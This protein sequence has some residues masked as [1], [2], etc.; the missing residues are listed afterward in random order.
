ME[1][2]NQVFFLHFAGGSCHSYNFFSSFMKN[3]DI[4]QLELPGRG[5]RSLEPFITGIDDAVDDYSAQILDRLNSGNFIV[6]GH[7]MGAL[8]GVHVIK[9]L[10]ELQLFAKQ[11][12]V[13][14]NA[15]PGIERT[16]KRHLMN[17]DDFIL[18]LKE[19]GGMPDEFFKHHS[20]IDYFF[21]ILRSD[22]KIIEENSARVL[23]PIKAPIFALMGNKEKES[24]NIHNWEKYTQSNFRY[25]IFDGNHF[26]IKK[27]VPEIAQIITSSF[28]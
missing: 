20:L 19:I 15:G 3:L 5:K 2:K 9:K 26:F 27:Y 4:H 16:K 28:Q 24:T 25:Q 11:L 17:T 1:R 8:I 23:P 22:F 21:P 18:E 7:S 12:I 6:F 13:S 14:G 10:E